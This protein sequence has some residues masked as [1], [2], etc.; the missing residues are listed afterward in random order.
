LSKTADEYFMLTITVLD[1]SKQTM[2]N[3]E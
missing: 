3:Y 1:C 2:M